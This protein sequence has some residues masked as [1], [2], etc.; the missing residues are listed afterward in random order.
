MSA[1]VAF[2]RLAT[3]EFVTV[4]RWYA[5]RSPATES[6]FVLAIDATVSRIAANPLAGS[7]AAGGC[8]WLRVRRFPYLLYYAPLGPNEVVVYAVAHASR[9]LNYWRGR[10]KRPWAKSQ[11]H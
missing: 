8:R 3:R 7:P 6:R 9:Q 11:L 1:T 4:R 10:M 2:H 5:G